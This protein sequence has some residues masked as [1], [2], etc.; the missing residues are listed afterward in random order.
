MKKLYCNLVLAS[1][2]FAGT[3]LPAVRPV[4]VEAE[5]FQNT[6]GWVND[7][8]FMDQMGSPFLLAHGLGRPVDDAVTKVKVS[9]N[10]KYRVWVRTRDWVAQWTK[11]AVA[12]PG[13]FQVVINDEPLKTVFGTEGAD[14]HWQ[15]GGIVEITRNEFSLKLHDLTG[16]EGRCDAILF[17]PDLSFVPPNEASIIWRRQLLGIPETPRLEGE[18]DLVVVGGGI[19]GMTTA[20]SAGRLGLKVALIHDRPVTGGNASPEAGVGYAGRV[21][22]APYSNVGLLTKELGW[23][24]GNKPE[25][26]FGRAEEACTYQIKALEAAGV[27]LFLSFHVNEVFTDESGRIASVAARNIVNSDWIRVNGTW[28]ADCTG[29][30][31][32]GFLAGADFDQSVVLMGRSNLW[33]VE[34]TKSPVAF[35]RCPWALDLTNKMFPGRGGEYASPNHRYDGLFGW[36]WESGFE[37]DPFKESEWIRDNNL[38]AM[39]GAWD[40]LKNVDKVYPN[41]IISRARYISGKRE[42]RRLLGDVI[43]TTQDLKSSKKYEDGCVPVSWNIDIHVANPLFTDK[44]GEKAG[45]TEWPFI[46][47]SP[48]GE[49]TRYPNRPYWMPYRC[50]YSRNISNLFMAGRDV[51]VTHEALG[52]TRVQPQ[53]GM[54]GE[55]VGMAAA[56][57]KKYNTTP[58]GV[59][60]KYLNELKG[61]MD[62][63]TGKKPD[64]KLL[65]CEAFDFTGT[66]LAGGGSGQ[67]WN[68]TWKTVSQKSPALADGN[69]LDATVEVLEN[70]GSRLNERSGGTGAERLLRQPISLAGGST[71]LTFLAKRTAGGIF[72][73][74]TANEKRQIRLGV[75]VEADGTLSAVGGTAKT[76]SAPGVFKPDTLYRVVVLFMN[77]G[78]ETGAVTCV[79]LY[80]AGKQSVPGSSR[81]V[82]WDVVTGGSNTGASQDRLMIN[83][84]KGAVELDEIR[85][86]ASWESVVAVSTASTLPSAQ[87]SQM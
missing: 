64:S 24:Y 16:F 2:L 65:A 38:R 57:C 39:Y 4:L 42:S 46:A 50:L 61:L 55:I 84:L 56:L 54:M 5:S 20:I 73:I 85:I 22:F 32:V 80:E 29:D 72:R 12:A 37:R 47:D 53:T 7:S 17:S 10:G 31:T 11:G 18:Y 15:D 69:L 23:S 44:V 59:Y 28:F 35:P 77:R 43:L 19:A 71:V 6:G 45:F 68:D 40:C 79:K 74:E 66:Q 49:N 41:H 36:Y 86:G 1:L 62:A 34:N 52:A 26:P 13:Q 81:D 87:P 9:A 51:S 75:S 83:I 58:R 8:Q 27:K 25:W 14:W 21:C 70:T 30:G 78:G 63:G 33:N 82:A 67:G 76:S 60:E 3:G 48:M